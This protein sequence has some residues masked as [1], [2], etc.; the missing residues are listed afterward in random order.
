MPRCR[1]AAWRRAS[2]RR[3]SRIVRDGSRGPCHSEQL[4]AD[5]CCT[6]RQHRPHLLGP[7]R[8]G[9]APSWPPLRTGSRRTRDRSWPDC[10][11]DGA[12]YTVHLARGGRYSGMFWCRRGRDR[13]LGRSE[14]ARPDGEPEVGSGSGKNRRGNLHPARQGCRSC[15]RCGH[16]LVRCG[17]A[18]DSPAR[19]CAGPG[20]TGGRACPPSRR[21]P[22][23]RP[24]HG[25]GS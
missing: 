5:A 25:V 19:Q 24:C 1:C 21:H 6:C 2:A 7:R 20:D 14:E 10:S 11:R 22:A 13:A 17:S 4:C 23:F 3:A 18:F 8:Q 15:Q 16:T 9:A 12:G